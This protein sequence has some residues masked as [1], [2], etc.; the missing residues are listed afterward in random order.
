MKGGHGGLAESREGN[1][2]RR[3]RSLTHAR[4]A[5]PLNLPRA[6]PTRDVAR[7]WFRRA[8]EVGAAF[9][10]DTVHGGWAVTSMCM[11]WRKRG[12]GAR[13]L[14]CCALC[15]VNAPRQ[16][17]LCTRAS[18]LLCL[19]AQ[20]MWAVCPGTVVRASPRGNA[21]N[22]FFS[23]FFLESSS[24][25]LVA[26][27]VSMPASAARRG[28][29]S[30]PLVPLLLIL[31]GCSVHTEP[32]ALDVGIRQH[33]PYHHR[34]ETL[35][36]RAAERKD[37]EIAAL[38]RELHS[39]RSELATVRSE[40][41]AKKA[42]FAALEARIA[43]RRPGGAAEHV[44]SAHFASRHILQTTCADVTNVTEMQSWA[45]ARG[46]PANLVPLISSCSVIDTFGKQF[47]YVRLPLS[48]CAT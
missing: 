30:T 32:H 4:A 25:R 35:Q 23:C 1:P 2:T 15:W 43:E 44:A 16:N 29:G 21:E 36:Q 37:A 6:P 9:R 8:G 34:A 13:I 46:I 45:R 40:L 48:C 38:R 3:T 18:G 19:T 28:V 17:N 12:G 42:A 31:S 14:C 47:G 10:V 27:G 39:V 22:L 7:Q 5:D 20:P 41:A 11:Y 24:K 26:R 33:L